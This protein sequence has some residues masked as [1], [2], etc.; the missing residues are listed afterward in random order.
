ML[1]CGKFGGWKSFAPKAESLEAAALLYANAH[2]EGETDT[3]RGKWEAFTLVLSRYFGPN[4]S[5]QMEKTAD[6]RLLSVVAQLPDPP[7][8]PSA[9][10]RE[11]HRY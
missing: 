1:Q 7:H 6:E 5:P 8:G 9:R 10:N 2:K 11:L 3:S 4:V